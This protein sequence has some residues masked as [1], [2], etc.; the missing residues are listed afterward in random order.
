MRSLVTVSTLV[1]TAFLLPACGGSDNPSGSDNIGGSTD[2]PL[3][4]I[5]NEISTGSIS[6][7]GTSYDVGGTMTVTANKDGLITLHVNADLRNAPALLAKANA[8]IPSQIGDGVINTDI[9]MRVTDKG[10]QDFFNKDKKQQTLVN[11]S[12]KVG[13]TYKVTKSDG[14]TIT[15][16]V[17][18]V[19]TQDDFPYGFMMIKT[20]TIEQ[21][22]RIPGVQKIIYRANH[23]FGLVFVEALLEDGTRLGTYLYP[24]SY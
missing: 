23:R 22:S 11:Y 5:G 17:T 21:D 8:W 12:A 13:D 9:Q 2:I 3:N 7:G 14:N 4:T 19:S 20:I 16:T 18:G 1:V 15:R 6:L 24:Q 10:I